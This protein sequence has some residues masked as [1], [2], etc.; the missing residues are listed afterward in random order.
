[1]VVKHIN[2]VYK[3]EIFMWQTLG[4]TE[5]KR[6]LRTSTKSRINKRGSAVIG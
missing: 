5:I 1:M 3:G 2:F 4:I 6:M